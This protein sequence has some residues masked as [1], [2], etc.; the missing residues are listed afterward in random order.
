MPLSADVLSLAAVITATV[1]AAALAVSALKARPV[2]IVRV[3]DKNGRVHE[4]PAD[5]PRIQSD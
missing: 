5:D 1:G 3:V 4:L 2:P